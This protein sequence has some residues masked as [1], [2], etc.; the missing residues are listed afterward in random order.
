MPDDVYYLTEKTRGDKTMA[1][2]FFSTEQYLSD[3]N[4]Y[5]RAA[6]YIAAT[7][8]YLLDNPMLREPLVADGESD[9]A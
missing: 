5:W 3:L 4:A 6:N 8:L 7:Q 2:D 1:N 9:N